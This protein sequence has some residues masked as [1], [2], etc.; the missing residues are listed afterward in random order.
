[1][2]YIQDV[3]S[4]SAAMAE[5]PDPITATL[6]ARAPIAALNIFFKKIHSPFVVSDYSVTLTREF[7]YLFTPA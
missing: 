3:F 4:F 7:E 1:M 2:C 6:N 5:N